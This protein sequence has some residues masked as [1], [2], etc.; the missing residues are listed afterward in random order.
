MPT[1]LQLSHKEIACLSK[2]K[3]K[4]SELRKNISHYIENS[5]KFRQL[6]LEDFD[7]FYYNSGTLQI[8]PF[9][10]IHILDAKYQ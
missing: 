4:K 7:L 9:T 10:D 5:F 3:I 8:F 2:Q 6:Y 1:Q